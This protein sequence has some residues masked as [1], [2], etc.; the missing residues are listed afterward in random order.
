MCV[1]VCIYVCMYL[2]T[3][4]VILFPSQMT[5]YS[6]SSLATHNSSPRKNYYSPRERH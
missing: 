5:E 1:F 6:I 4:C 3:W 2:W